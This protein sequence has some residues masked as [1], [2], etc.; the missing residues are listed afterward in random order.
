[1][2]G[3]AV[4]SLVQ[5]AGQLVIPCCDLPKTEL[6]KIPWLDTPNDYYFW[7]KEALREGDSMAT[8]PGTQSQEQITTHYSW[9][10]R[11]LPSSVAPEPVVA[12][13]CQSH[14]EILLECSTCDEKECISR[15]THL[16][17]EN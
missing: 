12:R 1:M 6:E 10:F 16:S 8:T 2:H 7:P 15:C 11:P 3:N 14:P 13:F 9:K 17:V 5:W 4:Q